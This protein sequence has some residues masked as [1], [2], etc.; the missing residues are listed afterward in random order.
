M[1]DLLKT[2]AHYIV[3]DK[4][5][6]EVEEIPG[7]NTSIIEVKVAKSDYGKMIGKNGRTAQSIRNIVYA[8]SFQFGKRYTIEIITDD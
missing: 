7:E 4:D 5:A 6:V 8:S 2:I 3:E 1:K